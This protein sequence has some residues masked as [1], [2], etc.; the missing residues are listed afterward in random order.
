MKKK[1]LI[2]SRIINS[3]SVAN[4]LFFIYYQGLTFLTNK[5]LN[6]YAAILQTVIIIFSV[7]VWQVCFVILILTKEY[8]W[9]PHFIFIS[10]VA[11]V[12]Y[13]FYLS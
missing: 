7:I 4:L 1:A 8:N 2:A 13:I 12:F 9:L 5:V 3:L 10:I 6:P 11:F